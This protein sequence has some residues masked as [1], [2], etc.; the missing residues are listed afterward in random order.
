MGFLC[1]KI[2]IAFSLLL[3]IRCSLCKADSSSPVVA[4][5]RTEIVLTVTGTNLVHVFLNWGLMDSIGDSK[6]RLYDSWSFLPG[7]YDVITLSWPPPKY[8]KLPGAL[9][10]IGLSELSISP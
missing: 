10:L 9:T 7:L 1:L 2:G 8:E 6:Y 4:A 5:S 3:V